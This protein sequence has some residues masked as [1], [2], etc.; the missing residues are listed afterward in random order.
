MEEYELSDEMELFAELNTVDDY[1]NLEN[2]KNCYGE[3]VVRLSLI[4]RYD[5]GEYSCQGSNVA[6][7]G[8][9]SSPVEFDVLCK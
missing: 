7:T 8:Q 5:S 6:G 1:D 9:I 4:D 2:N 3:P